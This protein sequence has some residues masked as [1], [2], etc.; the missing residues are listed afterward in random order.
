M[1]LYGIVRYFFKVFRRSYI[2]YFGLLATMFFSSMTFIGNI[3]YGSDAAEYLKMQEFGLLTIVCVVCAINVFNFRIE[4]SE[5]LYLIKDRFKYFIGG[6]LAS[7]LIGVIFSIIP[8]GY[9]IILLFTHGF[10]NVS[11]V[12]TEFIFVYLFAIVVM[13]CVSTILCF[14]INGLI[15]RLV[16]VGASILVMSSALSMIVIN[17]NTLDDTIIPFI[18]RIFNVHD[19]F[20]L[21]TYNRLLGFSHGIDFV[22]DKLIVIIL[23]SGIFYYLFKK[24]RKLKSS[25]IDFGVLGVLIFSF[26]GVL[27]V[28]YNSYELAPTSYGEV[29]SEEY[30]YR[31][32][33]YDINMDINKKLKSNVKMD[34]SFNK[35]EKECLFYLDS[36][37]NVTEVLVN[38]EKV[39]YMRDSDTIN[40]NLNKGLEGNAVV[41]ISYD[42][43]VNRILPNGDIDVI[44][45]KN[46]VYLEETYMYWYPK[47]LDNKEKEFAINVKDEEII[48]NLKNENGIL[49]GIGNEVILLKGNL[50][51]INID[52]YNIYTVRTKNIKEDLTLLKDIINEVEN[53][54]EVISEIEK[55][56]EIIW[57]ETLGFKVLNGC[58]IL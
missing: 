8:L 13:A 19:D 29:E 56:K 35:N 1:N 58:V 45:N 24:E 28:G 26:I 12:L 47:M 30:S 36:M 9:I 52:G 6:L 38:G 53:K 34:M 54:D 41:E 27:Y 5:V 15:K 44:A 14:L 22:L 10:N 48:S 55:R 11:M 46:K 18:I 40:I 23:I 37:F 7:I 21:G 31:V 49:K 3:R 25:F 2:F 42:G 33:K 32:N 51:K 43:L 50:E 17:M 4:E 20:D 39:D 16:C 57:T